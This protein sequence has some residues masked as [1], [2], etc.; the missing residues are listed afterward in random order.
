MK[1]L[2][3]LTGLWDRE[4]FDRELPA[5]IQD[6]ADKGLPVSIVLADI[7][8]F[9]RVN[10]RHGYLKGD[11]VLKGVAGQLRPIVAGKG[12]AYRYG[13]D[14]ILL[15]LPNHNVDEAMAVAET[16]RREFESLAL[17]GIE[18]T[19]SFGVSTYP[20]H[21]SDAKILFEAADKAMFDAKNRGRNLV[22]SSENLSPSKNLEEGR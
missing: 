4:T 21:G 2:D 10:G 20:E 3:S 17:G 16:A 11:D 12:D 15:L 18:I 6:A 22:R 14:E 1:R 5:A 9:K 19:A 8:H 7:D 13:G